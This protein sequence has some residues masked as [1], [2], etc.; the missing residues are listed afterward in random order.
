MYDSRPDEAMKPPVGR[1][2]RGER[3]QV[4][5]CEVEL[6]V[7]V[8]MRERSTCPTR[9]EGCIARARPSPARSAEIRKRTVSAK[10]ERSTFGLAVSG[11]SGSDE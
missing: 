3:S 8:D 9:G 4:S 1:L 11:S 6:E 10:L 2:L 7:C 5:T